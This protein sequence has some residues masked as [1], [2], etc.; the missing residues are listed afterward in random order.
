MRRS[1]FAVTA[2]TVGLCGLGVAQI[3]KPRP[4]GRTVQTQDKPATQN[5]SQSADGSPIM[6]PL[7]VQKGTPIKVALDSEVRIRA[8][9]QTIRGRSHWSQYTHSTNC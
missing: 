4:Q 1:V 2:L 3:L 5:E 7:T 9:G 8:V 6:M